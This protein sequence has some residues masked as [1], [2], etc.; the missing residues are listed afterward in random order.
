[1]SYNHGKLSLAKRISTIFLP[2]VSTENISGPAPHFRKYEKEEQMVLREFSNSSSYF[3]FFAAA[4][5]VSHCLHEKYL[6]IPNKRNS[7]RHA[8]GREAMMLKLNVELIKA[9]PVAALLALIKSSWNF[10]LKI[11][12][13]MN[14]L[15]VNFRNSRSCSLLSPATRCEKARYYSTVAG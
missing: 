7:V 10:H 3:S 4:V 12:F 13:G 11:V 1:M 8:E 14:K 9:P 6:Q 15:N 5:V 2:L